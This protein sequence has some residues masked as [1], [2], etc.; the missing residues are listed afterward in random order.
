[1]ADDDASTERNRNN[2]P[3]PE[4]AAPPDPQMEVPIELVDS[5]PGGRVVM[6]VER[7]GKFAWL[8]VH[9]HI[10]PQARSEMAA[11][12]DYIIRSGLWRQNWQPPQT[13]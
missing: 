4:P 11:D 13:D 6:P 3:S 7:N 9:G 8:V 2:E 5:L 10:S 12:L 1:M